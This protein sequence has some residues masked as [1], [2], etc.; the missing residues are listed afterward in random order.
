MPAFATLTFAKPREF[1]H[2]PESEFAT[3]VLGRIRQMEETKAAERR[4][5]GGRVLGRTAVLAQP[6][7]DRPGTGGEPH[8]KLNPRVAARSKWSRIEALL[9][10]KSFR[11]A[12]F[13]ARALFIKGTR[14]TLV[15]AGT[16][17]LRR[18]ARALCVALPAAL[19]AP[20]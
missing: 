7:S 11:D 1:V 14:D 3:L 10:N 8:R 5:T 16:Y 6:W 13:T 4:Q 12:Y 2:L 18:F 20:I 9:R 17:W 15:P 19:P